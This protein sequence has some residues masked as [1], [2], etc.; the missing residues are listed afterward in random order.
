MSETVERRTD[1]DRFEI[2]VDGVVVGFAEFDDRRRVRNFHHT[3]INP[4]YGGRGLAAIVVRAGLAATRDEG[5]QVLPS[6][7]YVRRYIETHPEWADLVV[8]H[9]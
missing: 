8:P 2:S 9:D 5:L 3:E 7:S 4:E 6:C 1:P